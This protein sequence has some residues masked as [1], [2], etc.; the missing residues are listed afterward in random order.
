MSKQMQA[1]DIAERNKIVKLKNE[2]KDQNLSNKVE[3]LYSGDKIDRDAYLLGK[4]IDK[5]LIEKEILKPKESEI[6]I[7]AVDLANKIRED[8]LFEIKKQEIE[9]KKRLLENPMRMKQLKQMISKSSDNESEDDD[10]SNKKKKKKKKKKKHHHHKESRKRSDSS[11]SDSRK[12]KQQKKRSISRSRS[13]SRQRND[14]NYGLIRSN[15]NNR[16]NR[17]RD[18]DRDR[19]KSQA[20]IE[21]EE[22]KSRINKLKDIRGP[23]GGGDSYQ[24]SSK[25][26]DEERKRRLEE[27]QQNAQWRNEV[28]NQNVNKYKMDTKR[29]EE[30]DARNNSRSNQQEAS[31]NFNNM[32]RDAYVSAE[33]RI[34]RNV[35][36][37]QRN[38]SAFDKNFVRR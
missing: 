17:D 30:M 38:E 27:M 2:S 6:A 34:K 14:S 32:M 9:A 3:W 8:P 29:E 35:K 15:N 31:K 12:S 4:P 33:D 36:N 21:I 19:P 7:S 1:I 16:D 24:S 37:I 18:R 25:L 22:Y 20:Q 5:L 10:A 13:R 11:D 26:S 28:R 23:S